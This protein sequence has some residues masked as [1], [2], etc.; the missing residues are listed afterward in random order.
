MKHI[1]RIV[2]IAAAA[3]CVTQAF[4]AAP[5]TTK[6]GISASRAYSIKLT[7]SNATV[8]ADNGKVVADQSLKET[9][10]AEWSLVPFKET[11]EFFMVNVNENK[12]VATDG[13]TTNLS[14]RASLVRLDFSDKAGG[15]TI[16]CNGDCIG[17]PTDSTDVIL[18]PSL[19]SNHNIASFVIT[20]QRSLTSDQKAAIAA[21]ATEDAIKA[22]MVDE[23]KDFAAKAEAMK[24]NTQFAAYAGGYDL[25]ALNAAVANPSQYSV[26]DLRGIMSDV[27][28]SGLPKAFH[29]YRVHNATRPNSNIKSNILHF[30]ESA[31]ANIGNVGSATIG[32]GGNRID[33]LALFTVDPIA[34][35]GNMVALRSAALNLGMSASYANS[36]VTFIQDPHIYLLAREDQ[37]GYY[38][39]FRNSQ[40]KLWITSNPSGSPVSYGIPEPSMDWAFELIESIGG[41]KL[42]EFGEG[43]VCLPCPVEL[44][45]NVT[46]YVAS[47]TDHSSVYLQ[48]IGRIVPAYTPV[49]LKSKDKAAATI[50]ATILNGQ[51]LIY[52]AENHLSG[53]TA[54]I[55]GKT[56]AFFPQWSDDGTL[57]FVRQTKSNV[58]AHT[59][60]IADS[61]YDGDKITI[62]DKPHSTGIDTVNGDSAFEADEDS[63]LYFD[64][65][66]RRISR[67]E[68]GIYINATKGRVSRR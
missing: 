60:S 38:F 49:I 26:T 3:M 9:D 62:A 65:Q 23:M 45:E 10:N 12:F 25:A 51:D 64:I 63:D 67:P 47:T 44:P 29:Y 27:I 46:A 4:G 21:I 56:V 7:K 33:N 15:W 30:V 35:G 43:S 2:V 20:P 1:N 19:N 61:M 32:S 42:N 34:E 18:T 50:S 39:R 6:S 28:E 53:N 16:S 48:E 52:A 14:D 31:A 59:V 24:S 11:G 5:T 40:A 8:V 17:L 57:S 13:K 55:S 68:K 66:G 37:F 58:A 41:I 54:K 36:P 22:V